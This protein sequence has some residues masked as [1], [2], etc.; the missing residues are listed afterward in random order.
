MLALKL[1]GKSISADNFRRDWVVGSGALTP[2][3]YTLIGKEVFSG[4]YPMV[5]VPGALEYIQQLIK[6][7]HHIKVVTNRSEDGTL[8]PAL[9]WMQE[10]QV[11]L[12]VTGVGYGASKVKACKGLDIF[13]DDDS[14]KLISLVG[15]V[16]HLLLFSWPQNRLEEAPEGTFRLWSW[17]S[18]YEHIS[19]IANQGGLR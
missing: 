4:K 1:F 6:D 17:R 13:V 16:P 8:Q 10:Y 11:T 19:A 3:E 12:P 14:T 18:V 5:P 2:E 15:V 9:R 7:G